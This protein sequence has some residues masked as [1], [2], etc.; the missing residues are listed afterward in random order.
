[1][2]PQAHFSFPFNGLV[3]R[4][5]IDPVTST[6]FAEI[7]NEQE[8]Q[9]SFASIDLASGKLNFKDLT[10]DERW[11]TGMECADNG[12]LLLHNYQSA[13]SPLHK[14]IIAID[15]RTGQL[16]WNDYNR[17]FDHLSVNGPVM[18]DMRIQPRKFFVT[19]IKTGE[20]LRAYNPVEDIET[21]LS[22]NIP[23]IIDSALLPAELGIPVPFGNVV[24]N[25]YLNQY[26][27]VSLHALNNNTQ[28]TQSLYI[29]ENDEPVFND[30][31]NAGI[32]KLQP[33]AFI[34]HNNHLIYLKNK[35]ELNVINLIK[36]N[37]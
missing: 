32:Q 7:R 16:L 23:D 26:R 34:V 3:W 9:V 12:I 33:E 14:G 4:M 35:T 21:E 25:L 27:I 10:T 11:L 24:H 31:L 15:G 22:I 13:N 36:L 37:K 5:E 6:L 30:L 8:K 20:R 18:Y 1:M 29:F 2:S 28:L 17:G 19:D